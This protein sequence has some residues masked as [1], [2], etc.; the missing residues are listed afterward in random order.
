MGN[1]TTTK[2]QKKQLD[3]RQGPRLARLAAPLSAAVW[4][5]REFSS[6]CQLDATRW[7]SR[8]ACSRRDENLVDK[9]NTN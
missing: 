3:A 5:D 1:P 7:S 4:S 2:L 8:V 9:T 6:H